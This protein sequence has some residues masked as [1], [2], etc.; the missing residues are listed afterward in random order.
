MCSVTAFRLV[1]KQFESLRQTHSREVEELSAKLEEAEEKLWN[2]KNSVSGPT[3]VVSTNLTAGAPP[4]LAQS[5][6][7]EVEHVAGAAPSG[8]THRRQPSHGY[9]ESRIDV[10]N[11]VREEGEVCLSLLELCGD[12]V[13]E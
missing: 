2:Q 6:R 13:R 10:S 4:A 8:L 7:P 5:L 12:T 1:Q 9:E 3:P 11:M